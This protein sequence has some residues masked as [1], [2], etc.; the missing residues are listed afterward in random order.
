MRLTIDND[1]PT[2]TRQGH[3]NPWR[4]RCA[5]AAVTVKRVRL[6][7]ALIEGERMRHALEMVREVQMSTLPAAMPKV[8]GYD[9]CGTTCGP[10]ILLFQSVD[11]FAR[12]EPQQD[13]MTGVLVKCE[14]AA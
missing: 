10:E 1:V 14:A 5:I 3:A 12:G 8:P 6:T 4:R 2:S 7:E 9:V 13:D 11:A